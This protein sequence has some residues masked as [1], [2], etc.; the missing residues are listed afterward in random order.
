MTEH[1]ID[2]IVLGEETNNL[3]FENRFIFNFEY[4]WLYKDLVGSAELT[5]QLRSFVQPMQVE[6]LNTLSEAGEKRH[7][8][9]T[10][11]RDILVDHSLCRRLIYPKQLTG[12]WMLCTLMTQ[13]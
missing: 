12:K 2:N 6:A 8:I 9:T 7:T 4:R 5:V 10:P 13:S 11:L 3:L 1:A